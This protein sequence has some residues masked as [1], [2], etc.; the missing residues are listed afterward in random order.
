MFAS[1]AALVLSAAQ[2]VA[3]PAQANPIES[4]TTL[5][6]A[7]RDKDGWS[8]PAPPARIHGNTYYVGT[9]GITVLLVTSPQGHVLIDTGPADAAP[10]IAANITRLGFRLRDIRLILTTHEHLDHVGGIAE[11]QRL[12]GAQV[13]ARSP[14]LPAYRT[15][16]PQRVD[17]QYGSFGGF[18]PVRIGR[19]LRDGEVVAVGPI[20]ITAHATHGHTVGST[21]YT[22]RSCQGSECIGIAF[23]DS[24]TAIAA[25]GYRFTNHPEYVAPF[26]RTLA[27]VAALPGCDLLM[28]PHPS[29][30][31]MFAR[32][33]GEA[34]AQRFTC[35]DYA[36]AAGERLDGILARE[37]GSR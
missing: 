4:R 6:R 2:P 25:D 33:D 19:V 5:S 14:A 9:C 12:T 8:D 16:Q 22:W 1:L 32:F 10:Q 24:L 13:A 21:S 30:S 20:R 15:G 23:V 36:R 29:A 26:R 31:N 17:P 34:S 35:A 28:T 11:L 27:R 7:C 3:T 18:A 37:A